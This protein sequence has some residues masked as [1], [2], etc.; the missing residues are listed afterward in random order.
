MVIV[1]W[2]RLGVHCFVLRVE[3]LHYTYL[4]HKI[5][6]VTL[7][8]LD[9]TR[10][11]GHQLLERAVKL[12]CDDAMMWGALGVALMCSIQTGR[13]AGDG[14]DGCDAGEWIAETVARTQHCFAT[15]SRLDGHNVENLC[16]FAVFTAEIE[17]DYPKAKE[18]FARALRVDPNHAE[19]LLNY[20]NF[21]DAQEQHEHAMRLLQTGAAAHPQH[22]RLLACLADSIVTCEGNL[23]E[24]REFFARACAC[25]SGSSDAML[26]A[27][28][29][30]F[31]MDVF[32]DSD[33][34]AAAFAKAAGMVRGR[35]EADVLVSYATFLCDVAQDT[36]AS[37]GVFNEA[38]KVMRA[39]CA[40]CGARKTFAAG[41][42]QCY[43]P[44]PFRIFQTQVCGFVA[45]LRVIDTWLAASKGKQTKPNNCTLPILN[46]NTHFHTHFHSLTPPRIFLR[47]H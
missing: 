41:P 4:S 7:H 27:A 13:Q 28:Y 12:C 37:D 23:D 44:W 6:I 17:G 3:L 15:A 14:G 2:F 26:H 30:D 19:T 31:L 10:S 18:L 35:G 22:A 11:K 5:R 38:L 16:N 21:L 1:Y 36:D 25:S 20:A 24:A 47:I 32:G 43:H 40:A 33:A 42:V 39:V 8:V 34:A 46:P 9:L 45:S 29:A